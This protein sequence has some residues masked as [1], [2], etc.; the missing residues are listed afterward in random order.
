MAELKEVFSRDTDLQ[1]DYNS[2]SSP[3]AG[4]FLLIEESP[5]YVLLIEDDGDKL[6]I[7]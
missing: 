6:L 4:F 7:E 1:T 3:P 2:W 5:E